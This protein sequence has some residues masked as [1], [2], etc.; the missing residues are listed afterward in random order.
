MIKQLSMLKR[1]KGLTREQFLQHWKKIHGP[2]VVSKNIPGLR[3]YV[4]NHAVPDLES[5][6]DGIAE[7]WYVDIESAQAFIHW[8]FSSDEAEDLR[9]DLKLFV[10]MEK[11]FVFV[12][13]EH[14][15]KEE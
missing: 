7:L 5:D 4:Q 6:I 11:T 10:D 9:E 12:A 13:E 8:L 1:K 15:L 2:L 3:R 14:I